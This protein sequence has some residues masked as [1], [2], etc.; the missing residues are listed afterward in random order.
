MST[1]LN[2][3]A[4]FYSREET[5]G[6]PPATGIFGSTLSEALSGRGLLQC[7]VDP[8][9]IALKTNFTLILWD[10]RQVQASAL[11]TG[12]AII[13]NKIDIFVDTINEAINLGVK[14]VMAVLNGGSVDS[15]TYTVQPGDSLSAI[16]QKFYGDGS[17][18]SWRKIYDANQA[19]IG[20]D[21]N[22][23]QVGMVLII[24]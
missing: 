19:V 20:P 15:R 2:L 18:Q 16:A 3:Q 17:E 22:Q 14:S 8:N 9:V 23:I 24:P 4:T 21:P 11:D 1:Q 12:T 13:G 10:G 5:Q 6:N 7:A